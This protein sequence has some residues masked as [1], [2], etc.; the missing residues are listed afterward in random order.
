MDRDEAFKL[1][2]GGPEGIA[3]WNRRRDVGEGIPELD[4]ADLRGASL[5][6]ANLC[7]TELR[8]ADLCDTNLTRANLNG[9]DLSGSQL[10]GASLLW[11]TLIDTVLGGANLI[12]ASLAAANLIRT[13]L[14]NADLSKAHCNLT[15]FTNVDL[16][17]V[18]HLDSIQHS[19]PSTIG[20][21]TLFRSKGQIP[22]AFLRGCG[23]PEDVIIRLP[24]L[25]DL[26]G[27]IRFYSCFISYN[28]KD[29][30]FAEK[31]YADLQANGVRCWYAPEDL[32]IGAPIQVGIDNSI[33]VHD[34]LLLVLSKNSVRSQWVAKEV[35]TAIKN[36][37]KLQRTVL[38]PIRLDDAVMKIESGWPADIRQ[39]RN[40]GEFLRWKDHDS[41][42]KA[43]ARLLK[44]L[45]A[46][47]STGPEP[48]SARSTRRKM[49]D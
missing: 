3:E 24:G 16:S 48:P 22:E 7:N 34:K 28:S 49:P 13:D 9:A 32:E 21:S 37:R 12:G 47:E 43:F 39:L 6:G 45:K 8:G 29:Q 15:V 20:L 5:S 23:V 10:S 14:K 38:F 41:Y 4:E 11:T 35:R 44:N 30:A 17:E 27:P 25:I 1:L 42:K 31:L 40:I 2:V 36:E 46:K 19:G 18:K 33:G 26:V